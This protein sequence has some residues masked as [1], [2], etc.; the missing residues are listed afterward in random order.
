MNEN[1]KPETQ[2]DLILDVKDLQKD[3]HDST[4]LKQI[5]LGWE[6]G[7]NL[8]IYGKNNSG[9]STL[10]SLVVSDCPKWSK[11]FNK[12]KGYLGIFGKMSSITLGFDTNTSSYM[13]GNK[14]VLWDEL[15]IY[16]HFKFV[17]I[18][19]GTSSEKKNPQKCPESGLRSN[20]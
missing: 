7:Q 12:A 17:A 2:R 15:D 20:I 3:Q 13:N 19:R 6:Q 4:S 9:K 8:G 16:S 5:S 18:L 10:M 14:D 1:L 11:L